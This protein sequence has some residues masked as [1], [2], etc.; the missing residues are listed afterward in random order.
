VIT[1]NVNSSVGE[2]EL[3]CDPLNFLLLHFLCDSGTKVLWAV[4][5][6]FF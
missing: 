4:F 3:V 5:G 2:T 6:L 1:R